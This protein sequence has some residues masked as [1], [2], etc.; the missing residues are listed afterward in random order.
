MKNIL[1]C[2][3]AMLSLAACGNNEKPLDA[4][5]A[6]DGPPIDALTI[7]TPPTLGAQIDRFGRPAINTAL[8]H[9]FDPNAATAGSAKNAY[10]EDMGGPAS[11]GSNVTYLGAFSTSLAILD[12]IDQGLAPASGSAGSACG[13]QIL[14]DA[15]SGTA[16][17]ACFDGSGDFL[18]TCSYATAAGFSVDD[19]LY[20]E[21]SKGTC[22][23]YL[24]VELYTAVLS[25]GGVAPS[26]GGRTPTYDVIS[27][28]LSAVAAFPG[29]FNT[30]T[31][32]P[33]ITDGVT[34]HTDLLNDGSG[35]PTF[36]FLGTPHANP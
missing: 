28:T 16:V 15:G 26:C 27:V 24:A 21:T 9:A 23:L 34:A 2:S 32:A 3:V 13:N 18:P 14:Y 30:T 7:P 10:N 20:I 5:P 6:H 35:N 12:S 33:L 11:W 4:A 25:T 1:L 19:E 22:D 8:N 36:P 17:H 31:L 29:A